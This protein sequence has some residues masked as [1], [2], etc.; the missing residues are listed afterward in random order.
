MKSDRIEINAEIE[1]TRR[2]QVMADPSIILKLITAEKS[3]FDERDVARTVHRYTD[4]YEDFQALFLRVG[5]RK[6][7]DDRI[8]DL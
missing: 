3:V 6:S 1:A 5:A 7:G 8:T 2:Q 4:S